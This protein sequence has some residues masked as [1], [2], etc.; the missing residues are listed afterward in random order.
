VTSLFPP[1]LARSKQGRNDHG[2]ITSEADFV[3]S[4]WFEIIVNSIQKAEMTL[5]CKKR[6]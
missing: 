5:D 6:W 2:N 3:A 1:R 4:W